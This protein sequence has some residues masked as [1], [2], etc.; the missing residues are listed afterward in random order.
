MIYLW[1]GFILRRRANLGIERKRD[2][3]D[4]M[5]DVIDRF[6]Y[7]MWSGFWKEYVVK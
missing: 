1:V 3:S 5:D 4:K 2:K 6:K 7:L